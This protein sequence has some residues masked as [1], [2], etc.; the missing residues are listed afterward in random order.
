M[1]QADMEAIELLGILQKVYALL[2]DRKQIPF[3]KIQS[4]TGIDAKYWRKL[5]DHEIVVQLSK[6]S[7]HPIYEWVSISPDLDMATETLKDIPDYN[8]FEIP[9]E[10]IPEANCYHKLI[11]NPRDG[12]AFADINEKIRS[13]WSV[14]CKSLLEST[15][16]DFANRVSE[17]YPEAEFIGL[18][19]IKDDFERYERTGQIIDSSIKEPR[20]SAKLQN[21]NIISIDG[22]KC[23]VSEGGTPYISDESSVYYLMST[24]DYYKHI[25]TPWLKANRKNEKEIKKQVIQNFP[26]PIGSAD[27]LADKRSIKHWDESDKTPNKNN[28]VKELNI[29]FDDFWNLYDKKEDK[30]SCETKWNHLANKERSECMVRLPAYIQSTPDKTYRKNPYNYLKGKCWDN[31]IITYLKSPSYVKK[32]YSVDEALS[33]ASVEQLMTELKKRGGSGEIVFNQTLKF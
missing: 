29:P 2:V 21:G 19:D 15:C 4:Q 27:N 14:I 31:E 33:A 26:Y 23:S 24:A 25:V 6:L 3:H 11:F 7:G 12:F 17:K 20:G 5:I 8:L 28:S 18:L 22:L 1:K 13:P 32:C 10:K 16:I 30:A 9:G